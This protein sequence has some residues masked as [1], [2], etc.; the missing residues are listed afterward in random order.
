[1]IRRYLHRRSALQKSRKNPV[2]IAIIPNIERKRLFVFFISANAFFSI[3]FF[4]SVPFPRLPLYFFNG[5]R[6]LVYYYFAHLTAFHVYNPVSHRAYRRIM[7]YEYY[8][9]IF[10]AAGVLK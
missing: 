1:M 2:P 7:R 6:M 3:A 9:H 5:C 4:I 8:S 10:T